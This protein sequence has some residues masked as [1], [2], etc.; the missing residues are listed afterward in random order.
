MSLKPHYF[1]GGNLHQMDTVQ[2]KRTVQQAYALARQLGHGDEYVEGLMGQSPTDA[3]CARRQSCLHGMQGLAH[4]AAVLE[5]P[6]YPGV[7][8]T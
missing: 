2:P 3:R 6:E 5:N 4:K 1:A 8:D 7:W